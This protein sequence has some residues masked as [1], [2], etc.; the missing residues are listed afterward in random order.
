MEKKKTDVGWHIHESCP[1]LVGLIK[2]KKLGNLLE[3]C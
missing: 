1:E 2:T 3:H